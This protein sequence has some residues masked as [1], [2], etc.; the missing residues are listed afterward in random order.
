MRRFLDELLKAPLI[1][2][3][4]LSAGIGATALLGS[5]GAR[6]PEDE[7]QDHRPGRPATA[8]IAGAAQPGPESSC[9]GSPVGYNSERKP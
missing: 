2:A 5:G 4:V 3:G 6:I 1:A 8:L 9:D 7:T